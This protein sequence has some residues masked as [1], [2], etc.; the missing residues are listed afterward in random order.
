MSFQRSTNDTTATQSR[1]TRVITMIA[2]GTI[3]ALDAVQLDN[4][5]TG[6]YRFSGVKQAATA[7]AGNPFACGVALN[8][9]VAGESVRVQVLG[10]LS[11]VNSVGLSAGSMC[12][13]D[14]VAGRVE[15]A[16]AAD[17][18]CKP[19][20]VALGATSSNLTELYLLDPMGLT[21]R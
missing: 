21:S 6:D 8:S 15:V 19:L 9:A 14:A 13:V 4:S 17:H 11:N 16:V 10:P 12:V 5:Q 7:A 20:A 2:T 18:T 1:G 3:T